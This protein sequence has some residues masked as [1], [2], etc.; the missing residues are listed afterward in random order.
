MAADEGSQGSAIGTALLALGDRWNLLILQR[1]FVLHT[2]RFGDWR[3]QLGLSESTLAA[4]LKEMVAAGLFERVPYDDNGRSR[5][6]YRMTPRA[7]ELWNLLLAIW[8]WEQTALAAVEDAPVLMHDVCG[9]ALNP[10]LGC[11]VC[12]TAGITA[13]DTRAE[14]GAQAEFARI[15]VP[16][17]HRRAQEPS[18]PIDPMSYY[19]ETMAILG[20]RWSTAILAAAFLG[21]RRFNAFKAELGIAQSILSDRL[22]RF[23]AEGVLHEP[24]EAGEYR[25][26]SKGMAF[27]PVY[28]VLVDWAQRWYG[29]DAADELTISH[30]AC[31]NRLQPVLLCSECGGQ[32][33]RK[34][35]HFDLRGSA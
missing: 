19:P 18:G 31:G 15:S 26:T 21:I 4:R 13:R 28:A 34:S 20:D 3:D 33:T 35:V 32:L 1:A 29:G 23:V 27:F 12:G 30:V 5:D 9:G 25:L 2:R 10:V 6:E 16:R 22:R 7:L 11:G 24:D 8:G 14:R 17:L